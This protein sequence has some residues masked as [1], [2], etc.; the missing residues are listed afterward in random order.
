MST[1]E[2]P[3]WSEAAIPEGSRSV[4]Q[5]RSPWDPGQN[6]AATRGGSASGASEGNTQGGQQ[7]LSQSRGAGSLSWRC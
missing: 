2:P 1:G 7:S 4:P 6:D 3:S 5:D